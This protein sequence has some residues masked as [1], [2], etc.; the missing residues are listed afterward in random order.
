M[1]SDDG[2]ESIADAEQAYVVRPARAD[3]REA[4]VLLDPP[5]LPGAVLRAVP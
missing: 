4:L 5:L 3:A 2:T 1:D